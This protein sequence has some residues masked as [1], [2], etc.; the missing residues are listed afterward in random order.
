MFKETR[1]NALGLGLP[2]QID[3]QIG[4][5]F[6]SFII[7]AANAFINVVWVAIIVSCK[8]IVKKNVFALKV[9]NKWLM[10]SI[11]GQAF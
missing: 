5:N 4:G 6:K 1:R 10:K 8:K 7:W 3:C 9:G 11:N 2:K